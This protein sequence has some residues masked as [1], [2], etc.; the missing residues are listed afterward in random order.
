[1]KDIFNDFNTV[2]EEYIAKKDLR[3]KMHLYQFDVIESMYQNILELQKGN[4]LLCIDNISFIDYIKLVSDEFKNMVRD[5]QKYINALEKDLIAPSFDYNAICIRVRQYGMISCNYLLKLFRCLGIIYKDVYIHDG[6]NDE[7]GM[8][9]SILD[10][11]E[12]IPFTFFGE[13]YIISMLEIKDGEIV[14]DSKLEYL[15]GTDFIRFFVNNRYNK[16]LNDVE[17]ICREYKKTCLN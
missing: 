15:L 16:G 10:G 6:I 3:D 11:G 9:L 7:E 1:M 14:I 4:D 2:Y 8:T 17:A 13:H 5:F 12:Y